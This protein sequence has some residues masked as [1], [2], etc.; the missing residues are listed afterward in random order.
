MR[1]RIQL[2]K[3]I[4]TLLVRQRRTFSRGKDKGAVCVNLKRICLKTIDRTDLELSVWQNA[5]N[6]GSEMDLTGITTKQKVQLAKVQPNAKS[7][8]NICGM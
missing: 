4:A 3:M 8:N 6:D 1:I 5:K 2:P 7:F